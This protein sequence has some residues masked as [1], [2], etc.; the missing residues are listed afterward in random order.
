MSMYNNFETYC[1]KELSTLTVLRSCCVILCQNLSKLKMSYGRVG[2]ILRPV[3]FNVLIDELNIRLNK[4]NIGLN[5]NSRPMNHLFYAD[6]S[7]LLA[8]TPQTLQKLICSCESFVNDVN[9]AFNTKKTFCMCV[10][11]KWFKKC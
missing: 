2:W 11:H 3:L 1:I 7:E 8:P 6:D 9:L 4:V 10:L 5:V